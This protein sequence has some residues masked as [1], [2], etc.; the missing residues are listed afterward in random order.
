M[1]MPMFLQATA[2]LE[3]AR[4]LEDNPGEDFRSDSYLD[5]R[6]SDSPNQDGL[7]LHMF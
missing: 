5:L 4:N 3:I 2:D 7:M 6:K 1:F